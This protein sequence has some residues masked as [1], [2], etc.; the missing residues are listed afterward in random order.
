MPS[1]VDILDQP[2]S[3]G[4]P[5]LASVLFHAAVFGTLATYGF[6]STTGKFLWGDPHSLGGGGSVSITPVSQIPLPGRSGIRNPV[7]NDTESHVP[8]PPAETKAKKQVEREDPDAISLKGHRRAKRLA[9]M[10]ASQQRFRANPNERHNQLYSSTGQAMTSAMFGSAPGSGGVGVGIGTPFGDRYGY[11]VLLLR[12]RVSEKWNTRD[13]DAR[14]QTAPPVV[15][16][17]DIQHDGS[18]RSV[19]FLQRSGNSALDFSAQ[20]AILDASP[21]PPLPAGYSGSSATIEFWFELKR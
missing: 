16:S 14:L 7:A 3:L 5:L 20:R 11:Y 18:V 13:V 9:D 8:Q 2:E 1:R 12:Q 6:I 15:V 21:F 17:F 19:R 10:A 4:K